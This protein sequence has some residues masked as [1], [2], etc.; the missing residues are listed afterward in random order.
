MSDKVR[1]PRNKELAP[2]IN[3]LGRSASRSKTRRYLIKKGAK[4]I[5]TITKVARKQPRFY[6]ADDVRR[7]IK[8]RKNNHKPTR[9]RASITPGTVLILLAGRFRGRRVVF[10]K[11]LESGLLLVTGPHKI[12]GVPLRRVNQAYVIATS[13]V[14]DVKGVDV[15]NIDDAFFAKAAKEKSKKDSNEFFK[16]E[17]KK[18]ELS[19]AR[20]E[21]QKKVDGALTPKISAVQNLGQYLGS[22]FTLTNN[23]LPH[24]IKF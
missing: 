7:P 8:S 2:G 21:A 17:N 3:T 15:K 14:V 16:E 13:T 18:T 10:L 24:D 19:A 1:G 5:K 20:K 9:L 22:L 12:N 11:Q 4:P 23:L 6:A